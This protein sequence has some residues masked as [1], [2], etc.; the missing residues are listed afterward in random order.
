MAP[1]P[2]GKAK[3]CN[4]FI[5][6]SNLIGASNLYGKNLISRCGEMADAQDLKSWDR[7]RSCR[8]DPDH[9]H[10]ITVWV[11]LKLFFYKKVVGVFSPSCRTQ[12][13]IIDFSRSLTKNLPLATFL[14]VLTPLSTPL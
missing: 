4:T 6:S 3:V 7:K 10:Q 13:E 1:S 5:I 8:F 9:R 11:F 14:N 2:S 12:T